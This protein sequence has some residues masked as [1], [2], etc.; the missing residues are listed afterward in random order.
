MSDEANEPKR[1]VDEPVG[2]PTGDSEPVPGGVA[3]SPA[4]PVKD[5]SGR[6]HSHPDADSRRRINPT[7][8]ICPLA[9]VTGDA[10]ARAAGSTEDDIEDNIN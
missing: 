7:L 5:E 4:D 10:G 6:L 1:A 8:R 2:G 9:P 3:D